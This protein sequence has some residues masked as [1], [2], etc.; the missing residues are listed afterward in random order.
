MIE[1]DIR[2]RKEEEQS[3][4]LKQKVDNSIIKYTVKQK[5]G[6]IQTEINKQVSEETARRESSQT[7]N[8]L[9]KTKKKKV[10]NTKKRK[11]NNDSSLQKTTKK[12]C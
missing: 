5:K 1:D 9:K 10:L 3:Y 12:V 7:K 6:I 4:M 8:N 2:G 11:G